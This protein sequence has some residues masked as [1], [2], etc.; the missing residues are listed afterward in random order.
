D[1]DTVGLQEL[2]AVARAGGLQDTGADDAA[3]AHEADF[4][5]EQVHAA[6]SALGASRGAAEQLREDLPWRHALG[7]GMAM[8]AVGAED[9]VVFSQV[10]ADADGDGFLADIGVAGAVDEAGLVAAGELLFTA[11]DEEHLPVQRRN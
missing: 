3:R 1:G 8:A 7:Q 5:G 6:A 10:G 11:A 9:D 4:G 2:E